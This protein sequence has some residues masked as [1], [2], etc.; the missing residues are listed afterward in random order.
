MLN[1]A[2]CLTLLKVGVR[3]RFQT[4][5][6]SGLSCWWGPPVRHEEVHMR[7]LRKIARAQAGPTIMSS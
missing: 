2:Q 5:L 4:L 3:K 1:L 6:K 7:I